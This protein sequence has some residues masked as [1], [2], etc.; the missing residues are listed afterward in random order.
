MKIRLIETHNV[1]GLTDWMCQIGISPRRRDLIRRK[2]AQDGK[3]RLKEG[4]Y[5]E[6]I[7]DE[8]T[9]F[10]TFKR[11]EIREQKSDKM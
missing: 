3:A 1:A 5:I 8:E 6:Q 11:F 10:R 9:G 4:F 7:T 2:L